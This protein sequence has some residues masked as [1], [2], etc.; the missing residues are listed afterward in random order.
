MY[1]EW[2]G[3]K[4]LWSCLDSGGPCGQK[5]FQQHHLVSEDVDGHDMNPTHWHALQ[6]KEN[7]QSSPW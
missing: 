3:H 5:Q 4:E 7:S 6:V 1:E 2:T